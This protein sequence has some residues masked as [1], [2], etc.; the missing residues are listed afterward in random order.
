VQEY[1]C[2][3]CKKKFSRKWN[4]LRHNNQIHH[5]LAIIYDISTGWASKD[6]EDTNILKLSEPQ[7]SWSTDQAILNILGKML[8]PLMELE[9]N[10]IIPEPQKTEFFATLIMG[11]LI[12]SDPVKMIQNAVEFNRSIRGKSKVI[13]YIS[14]SKQIDPI[15]AE[16]YVNS[17]IKNGRYYKNYTKINK[18][19]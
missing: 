2:T 12:S 3:G 9:N 1:S 16:V 10:L 4:A 15:Q 8:Q 13:S 18:S 17:L 11:S 19:Y 7:D 14:R 6:N 5:G